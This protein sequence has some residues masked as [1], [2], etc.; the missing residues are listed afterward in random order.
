M[1]RAG[2][3]EAGVR[4]FFVHHIDLEV[5]CTKLSS[6]LRAGFGIQVK[7]GHLHPKALTVAGPRPEAPPM[8]VAETELSIFMES[9]RKIRGVV[10]S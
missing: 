5:Q 9:S 8:T 7:D 1:S 3:G 4:R 10:P 2:L 6:L